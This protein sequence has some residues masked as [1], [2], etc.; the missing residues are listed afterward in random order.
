LANTQ[1]KRICRLKFGSKENMEKFYK[2]GEMRFGTFADFKAGELKADGR[3]DWLEYAD[4]FYSG[5]GLDDIELIIDG[6]KFSREGGT[7]SLESNFPEMKQYTHLYCMSYFDTKQMLETN[8][9][10]SEKNF[11]EDKDYV[12]IVYD[13][14]EFCK[15]VTETLKTNNAICCHSEYIEYC[16]ITNYSGEFGCFKKSNTYSYQ[17]EWRIVANFGQG[18]E[19]KEQFIHIGSLEDIAKP[20][21][22][23]EEFYSGKYQIGNKIIS[24]ESI[25]KSI[26]VPV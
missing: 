14:Q 5:T 17:N 23:K 7:L 2:Y 8:L 19:K 22:T 25:M 4:E 11:A 10:I 20:P 9:A 3:A 12:V 24:N 18:K 16:D 13:V 21:Q 15:R 1:S 6:Y 26:G